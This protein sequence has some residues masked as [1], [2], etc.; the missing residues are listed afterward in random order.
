MQHTEFHLTD[1]EWNNLKEAILKSGFK[2]DRETSKEL[3][4]LIKIAKFEGYYDDAKDEFE[5]LK[6]KLSHNLS[7]EL[8]KNRSIIQRL[9]EQEIVTAY[10]YQRGTVEYNLKHDKQMAAARDLLN[11]L[12]RYKQLLEPKSIK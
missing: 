4:E 10:Y 11:D 7:K 12:S 2:Y 8:D 6:T 1:A 3:D 9:V 5:A